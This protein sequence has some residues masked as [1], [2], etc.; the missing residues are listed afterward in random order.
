[1]KEVVIL[2]KFAEDMTN[3]GNYEK[4]KTALIKALKFDQYSPE[5]YTKLGD[6]FYLLNRQEDSIK[7]YIASIHLQISKFISMNTETLAGILNIKYNKLSK[8]AQGLLPC[9]EGMI[10]FEDSKVPSHI[11]HAYIDL[12]HAT[13]DPVIKECEEIYKQ[14]LKTNESFQ[15]IITN[16][17][18]CYDDYIEFDNSHYISLGRELL[19]DNIKWEAITSKSV[20]KL[21]FSKVTTAV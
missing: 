1:M 16:Y 20:K 10:I 12:K 18:L 19:V 13:V 17:N 4:A 7:C 5:I 15:K 9:K 8:E 3:I 2:T 11:A 21:Y 14:H 6:T